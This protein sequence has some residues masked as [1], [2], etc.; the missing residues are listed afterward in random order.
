[1]LVEDALR[2]A[3]VVRWFDG[4]IVDVG[5]GG[6]SPGIPLAFALPDRE[7]TLLEAGR[8]KCD[9]LDEWAPPNARDNC[10]RADEQ[11]VDTYRAELA[12]AFAAPATAVDSGP[13]PHRPRRPLGPPR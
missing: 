13:P 5:S 3:E 10:G 8:R 1:M 7:V 12:S 6:G 2:A 11:G 4:P 9:F